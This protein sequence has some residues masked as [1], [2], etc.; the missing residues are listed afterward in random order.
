MIKLV[1]GEI[2]APEYIEDAITLK[3][4]SGVRAINV[5]KKCQ[6]VFV[7]DDRGEK[8]ITLP[9]HESIVIKKSIADRVYASS[10]EVLI[11]GVSIY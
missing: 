6:K 9:P 2:E 10:K 7:I 11:A 1:V 4:S 8:S 3:H 5:S